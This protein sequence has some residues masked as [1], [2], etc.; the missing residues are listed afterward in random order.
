MIWSISFMISVSA[1]AIDAVG[2]SVADGWF[3]ILGRIVR[4]GLKTQDFQVLA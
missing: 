2:S 3:C 1:S 4:V